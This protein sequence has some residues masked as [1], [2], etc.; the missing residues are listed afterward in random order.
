MCGPVCQASRRRSMLVACTQANV[1]A[2][3]DAEQRREHEKLRK[4][5]SAL[6]RQRGA[7]TKLPTRKERAEVEAAEAVVEQLRKDGKA[8]DAR[9]KLTVERMRRQIVTLQVRL[10]CT[11]ALSPHW[12]LACCIAGPPCVSTVRLARC[13]WQVAQ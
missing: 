8:K 11:A 12:R 7:L 5:R 6:E 2:G 1:K 3:M 10:R 9:H 4:E 13:R